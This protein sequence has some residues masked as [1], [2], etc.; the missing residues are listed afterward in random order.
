MAENHVSSCS[1]GFQGFLKIR[2]TLLGVQ[3][4]G[5][6]YCGVYIGVQ[7]FGE[8]TIWGLL[9]VEASRFV[10]SFLG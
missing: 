6:E 1:A 8:T 9:R 7:L 2:G 10:G 3:M 4:I 5:L